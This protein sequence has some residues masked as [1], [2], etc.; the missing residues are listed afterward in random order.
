MSEPMSQK[1][2]AEFKDCLMIIQLMYEDM[3]KN[4]VNTKSREIAGRFLYSQSKQEIVE[5]INKSYKK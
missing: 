5:S 4:D 2:A 3:V 1:H